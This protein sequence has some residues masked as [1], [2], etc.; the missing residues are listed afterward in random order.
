MNTKPDQPETGPVLTHADKDALERMPAKKWFK[1]GELSFM[2]RNR[3]WRCDRLTA[4]GLLE[5]KVVGSFPYELE[6]VFRKRQN[7]GVHY[8]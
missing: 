4:F 6:T 8:L 1:I 5:S 2:I 7:G 3:R